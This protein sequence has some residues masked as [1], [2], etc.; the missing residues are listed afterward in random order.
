MVYLIHFQKKLYHAQHYIGF[1]ATDLIERIE[2][3]KSNRGAKLLRAVNNE[4]IAW[5]VVRVWLDGD[6][7]FERILKNYKKARLF[8]PI[9]G[10]KHKH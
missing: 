10:S 6:R 3:H 2:L 9:C 7:G 8:C 4:G 5:Q 1:V